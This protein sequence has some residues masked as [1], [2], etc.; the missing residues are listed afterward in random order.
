MFDDVGSKTSNRLAGSAL[1]RDR[2]L[3]RIIAI[4]SSHRNHTLSVYYTGPAFETPV[5]CDLL[6]N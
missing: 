2:Q 3:F 6:N 4:H 1:E 5:L